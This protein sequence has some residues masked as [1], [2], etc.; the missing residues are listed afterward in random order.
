MPVRPLPEMVKSMLTAYPFLVNVKCPHGFTP[1][2]HAIRGGEAAAEVKAL[3]EKAG[4]KETKV[5]LAF[6]N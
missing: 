2:H 3:L 1:L 6:K 4:A 5:S